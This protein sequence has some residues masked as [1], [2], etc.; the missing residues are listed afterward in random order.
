MTDMSMMTKERR[1]RYAVGAVV[2]LIILLWS[3]MQDSAIGC[4]TSVKAAEFFWDD[5]PNLLWIWEDG[6][7]S[8]TLHS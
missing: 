7:A 1:S 5:R 8:C 6:F 2:A 4:Y 3:A